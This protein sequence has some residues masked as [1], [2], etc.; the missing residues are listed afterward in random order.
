MVCVLSPVDS[1]HHQTALEPL[2]YRHSPSVTDRLPCRNNGFSEGFACAAGRAQGAGE[3][4]SLREFRW[5]CRRNSGKG[6]A[7][8]PDSFRGFLFPTTSP[9]RERIRKGGKLKGE[10][11]RAGTFPGGRSRSPAGV[12][13]SRRR[14][15]VRETGA[16]GEPNYLRG[17]RHGRGRYSWGPDT[18]KESQVSQLALLPSLPSHSPLSPWPLA[19]SRGT[20]RPGSGFPTGLPP[21]CRQ[22][23]WEGDRRTRTHEEFNAVSGHQMTGTGHMS[24]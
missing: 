22:F 19:G 9:A 12:L 13:P 3:P 24:V 4:D 5:Y 20:G 8:G 17:F 16:A 11:F 1:F 23:P 15:R 18:C 7:R 21:G 2:K 14:G 10:G 6:A